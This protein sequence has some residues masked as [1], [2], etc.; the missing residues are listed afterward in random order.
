MSYIFNYKDSLAYDAWYNSQYNKSA[1]YHQSQLL[2]NLLK[3]ESGDS[4]IDIGCGTGETLKMLSARQG[5]QL[6]GLDPS[7]YMLDFACQKNGDRVDLHRGF[8]EDLPFDDN[9]FNHA[10]LITTLEYVSDPQKAIEEAARVAKDRLFI[11]VM[12]SYAI[13]SMQKKLKG[14]FEESMFRRAHLFSIWELK[15]IVKEIIGSVPLSW[16]TLTFFP[17]V[18]V[19]VVQKN[20]FGSYLA[21][22]VTLEPKYRVRPL[23]LKFSQDTEQNFAES[24]YRIVEEKETI[25][26]KG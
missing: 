6:T 22:L 19:P 5:L 25:A 24:H 8:A 2:L 20:P 26:K 9:S 14:V 15:N 1:V 12:N 11:A 18:S 23:P 3:P 4:I 21:V 17:L 10:C 13:I 16:R 7:P